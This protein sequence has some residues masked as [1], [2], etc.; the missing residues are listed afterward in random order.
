VRPFLG[1]ASALV[2]SRN[3][4]VWEGLDKSRVHVIPPCIDPFAT[5]NQDFISGSVNAILQAGGL[6]PGRD[7]QAV[8]KRHDGTR[9]R[10]VH[11]ADVGGATLP[12]EARIVTQVSR[13]DRL[14]DPAG[15]LESF[16][17]H[18]ATAT[19]AYL[20]LAG[21]AAKAVADDP[22]QPEV[23]RELTARRTD[24]PPAVRDRVLIAQ[25]PMED[26]EENAAIVNALQR[27]AD[28]VVQKSLA[29]GFGLT[30]AEAMWK[31]R[32]VVAGRVGGIE[33]QIE[34]GKS[35]ILIDD[36]KD[37]EAFGAAVVRVLKDRS[38]A[39]ALGH[40]AQRRVIQKFITPCHLIEEG[41]L[42]RRVVA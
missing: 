27:R 4:Y 13:W 42:V 1:T 19:D 33:D 22:E 21:P 32:P 35:G 25:L 9:D 31:S 10:V 15:V 29:E 12:Y 3:A 36:P 38:L 18:I 16:A 41:R 7:G 8:F 39:E 11:S 17:R 40:E 2:F 26:T 23:F 34:D 30:V 28:V 24:L 6:L 20:V 14:K 37:L 5:K